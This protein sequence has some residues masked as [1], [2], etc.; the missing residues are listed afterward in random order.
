[1]EIW[2]GMFLRC[3]KMLYCGPNEGDFDGDVLDGG[4]LDGADTGGLV[5]LSQ[6]R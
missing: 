2:D 1:M 4:D 5:I 3:S 6:V